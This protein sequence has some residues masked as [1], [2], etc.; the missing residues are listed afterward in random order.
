VNGG[1]PGPAT[2]ANSDR[3][4]GNS[5]GCLRPATDTWVWR[6]GC[7]GSKLCVVPGGVIQLNGGPC[8]GLRRA[9]QMGDVLALGDSAIDVLECGGWLHHAYDAV[10]EKADSVDGPTRVFTYRGTLVPRRRAQKRGW[11]AGRQ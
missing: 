6:L 9:D 10:A 7:G 3:R 4:R 11:G 1:A 8:D 5:G 2:H